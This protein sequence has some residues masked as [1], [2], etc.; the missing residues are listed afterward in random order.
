MRRATNGSKPKRSN[1]AIETQYE[2]MLTHTRTKIHN[3]QD[4]ED[5][6][7]ETMRKALSSVHRKP[8]L[9]VGNWNFWLWRILHNH[10]IDFYR[11]QARHAPHL[12]PY[13]ETE[14][15][16]VLAG[17]MVDDRV[18]E[19]HAHLMLN[20]DYARDFFDAAMALVLLNMIERELTDMQRQA[21]I[22]LY[23]YDVERAEIAS[24][25]YPNSDVEQARGSTKSLLG[26]GC[27]TLAK[28]ITLPA[29]VNAFDLREGVFD[30]R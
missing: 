24:L 26:R 14:D 13:E 4:A 22:L 29:Y 15:G 8:D 19:V 27:R 30:F 7:Q 17:D 1:R 5:A 21:I 20:S 25:L 28:T 6:V 10:I 3:L 12:T 16:F 23:Y 18:Q 2:R 9:Q 11:Y